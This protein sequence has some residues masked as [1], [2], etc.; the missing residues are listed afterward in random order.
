MD[1]PQLDA[2]AQ[3]VRGY[4]GPCGLGSARYYAVE[5]E[6]AAGKL[7][8][9][10]YVKRSSWGGVD[11]LAWGSSIEFLGGG[12]AGSPKSNFGV[13]QDVTEKG[14]IDLNREYIA[15]PEHGML[16]EQ[17]RRGGGIWRHLGCPSRSIPPPLP[18]LAREF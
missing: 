15:N 18:S 1:R 8:P 7:G 9:Q 6:S 14:N 2:V 12:G 4:D 16:L 10:Q 11:Q 13:P 17:F 3:C 5:L